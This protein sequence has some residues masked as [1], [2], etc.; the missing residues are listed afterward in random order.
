MSTK[1]CEVV[2]DLLPLYIDNICSEES[3]RMVSEHLELC[4]ECSKLHEN[5]SQSVKPESTEPELD[6]KK[7]FKAINHK[8][9]IKKISIVCISVVLTALVVFVGCMIFQE[10]S[11]VHDYFDP[12]TRVNLKNLSEDEWLP[13][14]FEDADAL[15]FDSIFYEKE[16]TL[17]GNCVGAISIRISDNNGNIVLDE[18]TIEPGTSLDL[19]VLEKNTEYFVEIKTDAD[20]VLLNFH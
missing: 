16:V 19:N 5:M 3:R 6:S 15:V 10:V 8:W 1:Q 12:S 20:F 7:A 4:S 14:S 2:Q 17:D 9:K 13:I 11:V 18:T